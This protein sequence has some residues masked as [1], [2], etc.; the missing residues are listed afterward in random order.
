LLS[1]LLF[2]TACHNAECNHSLL[3]ILP[4]RYR[5]VYSVRCVGEK[6]GEEATYETGQHCQIRTRMQ[7]GC[8]ISYVVFERWFTCMSSTKNNSKLFKLL[9]WRFQWTREKSRRL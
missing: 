1:E 9:R 4:N 7:Q 3:A 5:L 8:H 6:L 2:V